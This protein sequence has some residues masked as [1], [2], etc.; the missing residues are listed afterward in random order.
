ML[1]LF[2]ILGSVLVLV[3]AFGAVV[4]LRDD[5][6]G[7]ERAPATGPSAPEAVQFRRV[8]NAEPGAC[9]ATPP[10]TPAP[11][12][13]ACGSNGTRYTLGDV[14]LDGTRV[15]DVKTAAEPGGDWYVDLMLDDEGK[16]LFGRLTADLATKTPPRNQL[17]IV[18]RDQVVMAPTVSSAI[19]GHEVR[20]NAGFTQEEADKLAAEITG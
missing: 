10:A 5:G 8:I 7:S 17:A 12:G 9:S 18:V 15:T 6:S 14:E 11:D 20:I 2:G 4:L 1:L 3:L 19:T 13:I 16:A